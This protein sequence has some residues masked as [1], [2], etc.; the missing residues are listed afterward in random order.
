MA[1]EC[2]YFEALVIFNASVSVTCSLRRRPASLDPVLYLLRRSL[3]V[4]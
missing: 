3:F 4:S 2:I 1:D